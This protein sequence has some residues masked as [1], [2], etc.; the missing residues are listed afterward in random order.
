ML[1]ERGKGMCKVSYSLWGEGMPM[2][3]HDNIQ[4]DMYK[5]GNSDCPGE[6]S[7]V[8]GEQGRLNFLLHTLLPLLNFLSCAYTIYSDNFFRKANARVQRASSSP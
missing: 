1:Y 4:N 6:I 8:V 2:D 5:T 7:G 3:T